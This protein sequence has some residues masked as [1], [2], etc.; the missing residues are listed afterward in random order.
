MNLQKIL[1]GFC[2]IMIASLPIQARQREGIAITIMDEYDQRVEGERVAIYDVKGTLIGVFMSDAKGV[3]E[4]PFLKKGE[5][6]ITLE[7]RKGYVKK[8]DMSLSVTAYNQQGAMEMTIVLRKTPPM[9][10]RKS[11]SLLLF[12]FCLLNCCAY[13]LVYGIS[14]NTFHEL[15][16]E[17]L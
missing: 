6:Q 14:A 4:L 15:L 10:S 16:D 7:E 17:E 13:V 11:P 8:E 3:I 1:L 2:F 9:T 5:Y 12:F